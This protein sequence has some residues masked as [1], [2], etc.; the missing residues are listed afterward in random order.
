MERKGAEGMGWLIKD[1]SR[2]LVSW[3]HAGGIEGNII[4][5][6]GGERSIEDVRN[7]VASFHGGEHTQKS[8]QKGQVQAMEWVKKLAKRSRTLLKCSNC[9]WS[10]SWAELC[11]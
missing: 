1:I 3:G 2:E 5:K 7:A 8:Q 9:N 4:R 10:R 11:T 6:K